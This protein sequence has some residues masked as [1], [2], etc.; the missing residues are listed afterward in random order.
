MRQ[1]NLDR[2]DTDVAREAAACAAAAATTKYISCVERKM[3]LAST[4]ADEATGMARETA[5]RLEGVDEKKP[6]EDGIDDLCER[7]SDLENRHDESEVKT[8][9][10]DSYNCLC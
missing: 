7:L 4:K 6:G 10:F 1:G 5:R 9:S 2:E 3:E 8:V